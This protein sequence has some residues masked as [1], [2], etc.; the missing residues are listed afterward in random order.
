[1]APMLQRLDLRGVKAEDWRPGLPRPQAAK[2]PPVAAVQ[3]ILADVKAGGDAAVRQLTERFDGVRIDELRVPDAELRAALAATPPALRQALEAARAAV[4]AFHQEQVRGDERHQ[5][6][7]VV[8]RELRR[9]VDRAGVYVPGGTAPLLSSVLMSA[10]PARVAGV[11]EIALCSPPTAGGTVAPAILAAAALSG[12]D[13]VY[14]IGGAQSVAAMA[15]GTESVP[16]VDVIVGPGNIYVSLAKREV[17]GEGAVGVPGSFAGPSEVV[18]VADDTTPVEFAAV[19]VV[20][21]AEHGP[22]GLAW[23]VTWS[24]TAADAVAAEVARIVA[25]SPRRS[26]IEA[27]L[28]EGGYAVLVDGPEQAVEV[29]NAIAP[30]HLELMC[31]GPEALVPL[32]RHAGAV[33]CGPWAPA[34]VGDYVAG[35]S[36]VLPTYG[37]A[38]FASALRVDDFVKTVH[39]I[40]LDEAALGRLAPHVVALAEAEGLAAHAESVRI[41]GRG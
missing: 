36:H 37:S 8:V 15:Y 30:E 26:Q 17:A 21:Q 24:E 16:A 25:A 5:R 10:V 40:S 19:D 9:A 29:A 38:R 27:T 18:V 3:A 31:D 23:L 1:M 12:V 14:R 34:S 22:D 11:A 13:E 6:E 33:F 32:V 7:G 35:P 2:E 41:R 39:V 28:G 20:V 4:L